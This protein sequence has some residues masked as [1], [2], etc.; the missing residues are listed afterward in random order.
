MRKLVLTVTLILV[1]TLSACFK[2]S[3]D[4]DLVK[5]INNYTNKTVDYY[6]HDPEL[7]DDGFVIGNGTM[8]AVDK[9]WEQVLVFVYGDGAA[10]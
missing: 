4:Q 10:A 9:D 2:K 6:Y 8:I 3:S 7:N 1:L 5:F